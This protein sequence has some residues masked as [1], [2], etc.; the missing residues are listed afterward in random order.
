MRGGILAVLVLAAAPSAP[1]QSL[2]ESFTPFVS[3]H[4]M[5]DVVHDPDRGVLWIAS[6]GGLLEF[7]LATETWTQ[8]PKLLGTGPRGNDLTSVCLDDDA[9]VWM[10]SATRGFTYHDPDTEYWDRF[11]ED[12]P[13]PR[14]RALRCL[15]GT[16]YV[17]TQEGMAIKPTPTRTD[18]C[19][20]VDAGCLIPSYIVNDFA[21]LGDT[22]WVATQEGLGRRSG[23]TWDSAG[24]L[25]AGS[26]GQESRSL[27]V[28][29]GELWEARDLPVR[30]LAGET[31][32]ATGLVATRLVVADGALH[33]LAGNRV[34]R[35]DGAAWLDLD[36]PLDPGLVVNDLVRLD[37]AYLL[38][39]SSGLVRWAEG[40]GSV[41]TFLPPGPPLSEP[42]AGLAVDDEGIVWAGTQRGRI[43]IM[44]TDGVTWSVIRPSDDGLEGTW[45]FRLLVDSGG[46]LWTGHC[47]CQGTGTDCGVEVLEGDVFRMPPPLVRNGWG[48]S[49]DPAGRIWVGQDQLGVSVLTPT[50][51]GWQVTLTM[52]NATTGGAL[53][54][55]FVR[56]VVAAS[57][58]TYFGHLLDGGVDYWP[59]GGN[60]SSGAN[61]TGW[62]SIP[63]LL[64][65]NVGEMVRVGEDIWVGTASGLH[66]LRGAEVLDRCPTRLRD[67]PD[68]PVRRVNA[69]AADLQGGLWLG[70]DAGL[71]YLARGRSCDDDGGEFTLF[72]EDNSPLPHNAVLSAVVNPR[73]GSVWFG[74]DSGLLRVDPRAY[75]GTPP[76]PDRYLLYPNPLD[77]RV[78]SAQADR[79]VFLGL[80]VAGL[81]VEPVP[82]DSVSR[83]E[84]FDITGRK[85]GD[86]DLFFGRQWGWLGKNKNGDVVAPGVYLVRAKTST[87]EVL[88]FR[89]GV[90]R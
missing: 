77:F 63:G 19:N 4:E 13:D 21:E 29:G 15:D 25:P 26:T 23:D 66:R 82:S 80:E 38:A 32:T 81:R 62:I 57:Q 75:S 7:T 34:H 17:G 64:D 72:T 42:V 31:W 90:L 24:S 11:T 53:A 8:H 88:Q 16:I 18:I 61:G 68:D 27:A 65:D 41:D 1:A 51:T 55:N 89:L 44:A 83:P 5:L 30:R 12:W 67:V 71:L 10:G 60:L 59:H 70:T 79:E 50:A 43:G 6:S 36:V 78:G 47:C 58:G 22:L 85:V 33:A 39:T 45:I 76:P 2:N 37:G 54:S 35:W 14:I 28:F 87:G 84:I 86:F 74:T 20:E 48:L 3:A 73:D 69:I 56:A 49:E 52:T 46:R 40:S 9:T